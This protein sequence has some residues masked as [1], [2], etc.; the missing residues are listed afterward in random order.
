M[1]VVDA[2][3]VV[4]YFNA[5]ERSHDTVARWLEAVDEDLVTT[6]LVL[7]EI[8]YVLGR[9]AG[10]A[11][12]DAFWA[13][14]DDGVYAVEWWPG[15]LP[16]TIAA[17]R[18]AMVPVGLADASLVALAAHVGTDR[19]ATLDEAHFGRLVPLRGGGAFLLMPSIPQENRRDSSSG[20]SGK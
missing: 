12:L 13:D 7:A 17:G 10:P 20:Y 16:E 4:A 5:A 6:P 3:V 9:R 8:D 2:S 14:L 18:A 1:I 15:A 11:A 19:I